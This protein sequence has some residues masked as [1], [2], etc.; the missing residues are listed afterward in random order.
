MLINQLEIFNTI[1]TGIEEILDRHN[2][3]LVIRQ[4][5]DIIK[6]VALDSIE[7]LMLFAKLEHRYTISIEDHEADA[8]DTVQSHIKLIEYKLEIK[9]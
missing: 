9:N 2:D 8:I 7:C 1:K 6:D 5:S 4:E 3:R